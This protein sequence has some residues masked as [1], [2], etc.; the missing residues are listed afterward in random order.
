MVID[1]K[2]T[3]RAASRRSSRVCRLNTRTALAVLLLLVW[4]PGLVPGA[5]LPERHERLVIITAG[6]NF[7]LIS[8]REFGTKGFGRL[9]AEYNRLPY[10]SQLAA[11]QLL[12]IP[13]APAF[14]ADFAGV[15]F[16]KGNPLVMQRGNRRELREIKSGDKIYS[17][18]IIKTTQAGFVSLR[19]PSGTVVNI[20]P[21]SLVQ[22]LALECLEELA[23][24]IISLDAKTGGI[25]S[26]VVRRQGQP[27]RFNVR[28]PHASAAVR[29]TV[30]D[31]DAN[32]EKMLLGVTEGNVDLSAQG[33]STSVLQG[34]GVKTLAGQPPQPPVQLLA[35]P[36]FKRIPVRLTEQDSLSWYSLENAERYILGFS[37]DRE[38]ATLIYSVEG[39]SLFHQMQPLPAGDYFAQLRAADADGFK[40][41]VT[42][43]PVVIA[44]IDSEAFVPELSQGSGN[45]QILLTVPDLPDSISEYEVQQS[46]RPDF[47]ELSSVDVPDDGGVYVA[48]ADIIT[49]F[50]A[51]VILNPSTVGEFGPILPIPAQ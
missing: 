23:N 28:T 13:V 9:I 24:C 47:L 39:T 34:L 17:E 31:I 30:F 12:R 22:L 4:L 40:G 16:S 33:R 26:N 18:D 25:T 35:G 51:R 27:T 21:N 42:Q 10:S 14:S 8:L 36:N 50:R 6:D 38:G 2:S 20:Q 49:Y 45:G 11:G 44:D 19:F 7:S 15:I 46:F 43:L 3:L 48:P 5:D 29:G 1:W 41:Y 32:S 37:R